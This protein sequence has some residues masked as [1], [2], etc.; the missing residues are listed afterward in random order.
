MVQHTTAQSRWEELSGKRR[1]FISRCELYAMY[2]LPK[3][4]P[5]DSYDQNSYELSHDFQAVGAQ[6]TNNLANKIILAL[7]APSRPFF[8]ADPDS[9]TK[10]LL[11]ELKVTTSDVAQMLALAEK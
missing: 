10:K 9:D 3:I 4:C 2:T 6:A 1:G 7:F 11:A 8:R 5:P